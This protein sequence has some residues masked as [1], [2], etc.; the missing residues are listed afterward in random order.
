MFRSLVILLVF[1]CTCL[2]VQAT[3]DS[4]RFVHFDISNGF[5]T[6]NV[7]SLVTDVNGYTWFATDKGVVK[8]NGYT[9][10]IYNTGNGLPADD[11]YELY[12]DR[13]GRVW[14]NSHSYQIGYMKNG[15]Y[16][17]LPYV[18]SKRIT[19]TYFVSESGDA[20]YFYVGDSEAGDLVFV[21]G[22]LLKTF[23]FNRYGDGIQKKYGVI[24][25]YLANDLSL[26]V[27]DDKENIYQWDLLKGGTKL[28]YLF[29]ADEALIYGYR[30][31]RGCSPNGEQ[32]SFRFGHIVGQEFP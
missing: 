17:Q 13:S 1:A 7:Y 32:Y 16:N 9:F 10:T 22:S 20:V 6:N 15:R 14:L 25:F 18:T 19:N 8:Y 28:E 12:A 26:N 2:Y 3:P 24:D 11:V 31:R 23:P 21:I 27:M 4:A 30:Y 5:P 29:K